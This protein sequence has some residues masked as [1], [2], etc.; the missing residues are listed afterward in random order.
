M[1][2]VSWKKPHRKNAQF[3]LIWCKMHVIS[4]SYNK[5][6][7]WLTHEYIKMSISYL[8]LPFN[9]HSFTELFCN[10]LRFLRQTSTKWFKITYFPFTPIS[11]IPKPLCQRTINVHFEF[12]FSSA[13]RRYIDDW[14]ECVL[15]AVKKRELN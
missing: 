14:I 6:K 3:N 7:K 11:S 9:N 8:I 1:T 5:A 2:W 13:I 4:R 15:A 10:F 12:F